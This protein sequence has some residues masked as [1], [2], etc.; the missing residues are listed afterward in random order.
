ML[1]QL[2]L[3]VVYRGSVAFSNYFGGVLIM[4][5]LLLS[6]LRPSAVGFSVRMSFKTN[7]ISGSTEGGSIS[8]SWLKLV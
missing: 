6:D 8:T 7:A 1:T 5:S 3:I 4:W 2:L